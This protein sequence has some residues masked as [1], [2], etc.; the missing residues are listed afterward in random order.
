MEHELKTDPDV[1]AQLVTNKKTFEIRYNDRDFKVGDILKLRETVHSAAEMKEGAQL[2]YTGYW[3]RY[4]VTHA[5]YGPKLG[6]DEGWV[7]MSIK[8]ISDG[9]EFEEY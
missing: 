2:L 6:I 9:P 8:M 7:V 1:F 5:I 4:E 3:L